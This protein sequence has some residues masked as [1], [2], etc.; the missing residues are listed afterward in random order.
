MYFGIGLLLGVIVSMYD[1]KF[2]DVEAIDLISTCIVVTIMW[3]LVVL[4]MILPTKE[5]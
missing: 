1:V 2:N 4:V 5:R 3:P